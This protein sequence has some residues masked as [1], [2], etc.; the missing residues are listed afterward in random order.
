VI[1]RGKIRTWQKYAV[2]FPRLEPIAHMS[3]TQFICDRSQI[4]IGVSLKSLFIVRFTAI[5]DFVL[6]SIII[7]LNMNVGLYFVPYAYLNCLFDVCIINAKLFSSVTDAKL[8][9]YSPGGS[10]LIVI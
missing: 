10:T 4:Q 3:K 5:C 1:H 6:S 2:Q 9:S 8:Y 7:V